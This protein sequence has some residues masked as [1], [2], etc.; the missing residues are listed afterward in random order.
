M[1]HYTTVFDDQYRGFYHYVLR[2]YTRRD[3]V[4]RNKKYTTLSLGYVPVGVDFSHRN[5]KYGTVVVMNALARLWKEGRMPLDVLAD[6][7]MDSWYD[8]AG[9]LDKEKMIT[10]CRRLRSLR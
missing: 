5:V 3:A 7:T 1:L 6:C 2:D 4:V 10:I 9:V 8:A